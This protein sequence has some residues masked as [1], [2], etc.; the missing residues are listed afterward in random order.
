MAETRK[1]NKAKRYVVPVAVAGVAVASI[2]L[3]PA[4]ADN[5]D[6]DLPKISAEELIA[7]IAKSD[8]QQVSGT[9]RVSADLGLP[10]M[11]NGAAV[12]L[13]KG[14]A[15]SSAPEAGGDPDPSSR[16]MQLASGENTL[17]IAADGPGKQRIVLG[18]GEGEYLLVHNEG[19]V[20]GYD[21]AGNAAYH[22]KAPADAEGKASEDSPTGGLE[23][24]NP[25]EAARQ[26][27]DA[28]DD[29]TKVTVDGTTRVAGRD[30]YQLAISP[31]DAPD[32]TVEAIRIAVDAENG[33]PLKFT[34]APKGGGKAIVEAG[35][36]K[37]DFTKP[38]ADTFSFKPPKGATVTEADEFEHGSQGK[39]GDGGKATEGPGEL[40]L[41][42]LD[43]DELGFGELAGVNGA[44]ESRVIGKGWNSVIELKAP[45]GSAAEGSG[46]ERGKAP[47]PDAGR[48]DALLDSFSEKAKG[49]FGTGRVFSTRL[50]NV[51][52]T[53]DGSVY[54]GAVTKEGLIK[55]ANGS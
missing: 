16:L 4:L 54:A 21:R 29:T 32:S 43:L 5:G 10:G 2:G 50:V 39:H 17:Q 33:S 55:A 51:L 23:H 1:S 8:V 12:E 9:V 26:A 45:E 7:K 22:A 35:F 6:P 36:T 28:V 11:Q 49:E 46:T 18:K 47:E 19:E 44:E 40:D 42:G 20:W 25:A 27:L 24:A 3:V 14:M 41:G 53:D 37:V 38:A 30:A 31:K 34:L 48:A 15:E 13:L 52:L